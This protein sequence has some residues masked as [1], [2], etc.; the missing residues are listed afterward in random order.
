MPEGDHQS[1]ASIIWIYFLSKLKNSSLCKNFRIAANWTG[2]YITELTKF[3][4]F[5]VSCQQK[6]ILQFISHINDLIRK[7][8]LTWTSWTFHSDGKYQRPN[9]NDIFNDLFQNLFTWVVSMTQQIFQNLN[10]FWTSKDVTKSPKIVQS[11]FGSLYQNLTL[12]SFILGWDNIF[13]DRL[14][15][16]FFFPVAMQ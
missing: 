8:I 10:G 7:F 9:L 1:H 5:A 3:K 12:S 15:Q 13:F 4:T 2:H 14:I 6:S 11:R 16:S